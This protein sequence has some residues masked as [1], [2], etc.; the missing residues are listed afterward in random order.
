MKRSGFVATPLLPSGRYLEMLW[1]ARRRP[2]YDATFKREAGFALGMMYPYPRSAGVLVGFGQT[3]WLG[4]I[5]GF[6]FPGPG[7]YGAAVLNGVDFS[8]VTAIEETRDQLL[9]CVLEDLT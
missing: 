4:S 9:N 3:S 5:F 2:V 6:A 7:V 1:E 8:D